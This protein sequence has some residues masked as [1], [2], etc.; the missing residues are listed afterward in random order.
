MDVTSRA[1]SAPRVSRSELS[2][3]YYAHRKY[4]LTGKEL[5]TLEILVKYCLQVYFK[6]YY[7]IKVHHRLEDGPSTSSRSSKV[8]RSRRRSS[9]A[10]TFY[11]S[12]GG[13]CA[14]VTFVACQH[15]HQWVKHY[16]SD[17]HKS[18][19]QPVLT[20]AQLLVFNC[21]KRRRD[22][23]KSTTCLYSK[24]GETPLPSTWDSRF[25]H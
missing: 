19:S 8:M 18:L 22:Y 13:L 10:V 6:L 2:A 21:I 3:L 7:D 1:E 17:M 25:M 4:G 24:D 12:Q 11:N 14:S 16:G 9:N 5:N 15:D 20:I 23:G